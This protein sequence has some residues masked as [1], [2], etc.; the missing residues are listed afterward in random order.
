M[1]LALAR[2]YLHVIGPGFDM[3][4]TD[5]GFPTPSPSG[6]VLLPPLPVAAEG[7]PRVIIRL[8]VDT[9]RATSFLQTMVL[10]PAGVAPSTFF[11]AVLTV[12][13]LE[14]PMLLVRDYLRRI[15]PQLFVRN[16]DHFCVRVIISTV[17]AGTLLGDDGSHVREHVGRTVLTT[18]LEH[19]HLDPGTER[20]VR[21]VG[22][23][24][25]I[26]WY[27]VLS[28]ANDTNIMDQYQPVVRNITL[29][30]F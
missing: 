3:V 25:H 7:N 18:Y 1:L 27:I 9:A 2:E 5:D 14:G 17:V 12:V 10:P 8:L 16:G 13:Q 15:G 29:D 30:L 24:D 20:V 22:A 6:V 4:L 26:V 23:L 19:A 21:L 28:L 11:G